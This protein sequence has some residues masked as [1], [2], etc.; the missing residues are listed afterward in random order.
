MGFHSAA[1]NHAIDHGGRTAEGK[2]PHPQN[3]QGDH[4][5][6]QSKADSDFHC[7]PP[8]VRRYKVQ[9]IPAG[10]GT[11]F[12]RSGLKKDGTVRWH[13][14]T[15]VRRYGLWRTGGSWGQVDVL[16]PPFRRPTTQP[17]AAE[18]C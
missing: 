10:V 8:L 17:V 9:Q 5:L 1:A 13:G 12:V 4:D 18:A 11:S 6:D 14:G 2:D 3:D 7:S 15:A 16:I